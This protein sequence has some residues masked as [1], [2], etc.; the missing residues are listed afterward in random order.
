MFIEGKILDKAGN[1]LN[2]VQVTT[3]VVST[4]ELYYPYETWPA[5]I[6]AINVADEYLNSGGLFIKKPGYKDARVS[7]ATLA[8]Y[9]SDIVLEKSNGMLLLAAGAG[10]LY[11]ITRENKK[12][13]GKITKEDAQ[14]GVIIAGGVLG[15]VVIKKVLEA[16]GIFADQAQVNLDAAATDPKSFWNPQYWQTLPA[17]QQYTRPI[18]LDQA[19]VLC[20]QIYNAI[21]WYNDNEEAVKAVFRSLPSRAAA[22][23][24]CYVF[25]AM[26]G[27][28]L[29]SW[30]RGG[31][32]P[33]DRLSDEDVF[34]ITQFVNRLP[35]Y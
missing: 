10:A 19:K 31:N 32:W 21:T 13:M 18:T 29:L 6:Y 16:L 30:L 7:F 17:G 15:W 12:S 23:F 35:A 14:T 26:Y 5:G 11:L 4:G 22:S 3:G 1:V 8:Y 24:V 34:E 27:E 25:S 20:T 28:D 33:Q 9:N 2:D